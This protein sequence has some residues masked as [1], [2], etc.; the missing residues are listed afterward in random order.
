MFPSLRIIKEY[1]GIFNESLSQSKNMKNFTLFVLFMLMLIQSGCQKNIDELIEKEKPVIFVQSAIHGIVTGPEGMPLEGVAVLCNNALSRTDD[2]G[3]YSFPSMPLDEQGAIVR[4][5][6]QGYFPLTKT[7][8]PL[9]NGI[10]Q[11][12]VQ[13]SSFMLSGMISA[14]TGGTIMTDNAIIEL[15]GGFVDEKGLPYKG[16]VFVY[17]TYLRAGNSDTQVRTPGN[18]TGIRREGDLAAL[19]GFGT[20]GIELRSDAGKLLQPS[21]NNSATI[22]LPLTSSYLMSAPGSIP[23]WHFDEKLGRWIEDGLASLESGYYVATVSHFS[24]WGVYMPFDAVY[25]EGTLLNENDL[26]VKGIV[27][28]AVVKS[29]GGSSFP[30]GSFAET[31]TDNQGRFR[32]YVPKNMILNIRIK[33]PCTQA[34]GEQEVGPLVTD[35]NMGT[36]NITLGNKAIMLKAELKNCA[37]QPLKAPSY[38]LVVTKD[39]RQIFQVDND[40]IIK[41]LA[42]KCNSESIEVTAVDHH[43]VRKSPSVKY[44]VTGLQSIDLGTIVTCDEPDEYLNFELNGNGWTTLALDGGI[45]SG[46]LDF[47]VNATNLDSIF[48]HVGTNLTSPGQANP[49]YFNLSYKISPSDPPL[50]TQCAPCGGVLLTITEV[51][52]VGG[53]VRGNFDGIVPIIGQGS[54]PIKG[55]FKF[56]RDY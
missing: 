21:E 43:N 47:R 4:F 28:R 19:A 41:V 51:G 20:I 25:L 50:V 54:M 24:W 7:I 48:M 35:H 42:I 2:N 9:K 52:N 34:V 39:H 30:P 15:K 1:W 55:S 10:T 3:Y 38:L 11:L 56:I 8:L 46:I 32:G 5:E 33:A 27:V 49:L 44:T 36:F 13:L 53:V 17:A 22:K 23:L 45:S 18:F 16:T 6:G 29:G 26:P 31:I 14:H 12:N 40:G 37:G